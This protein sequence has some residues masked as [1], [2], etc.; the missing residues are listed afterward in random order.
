MTLLKDEQ[1]TREFIEKV[2]VPLEKD[3]VFIMV[4][5]ARKKYCADISSS[6]E[7]VRKDIIRNNDIDNIII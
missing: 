2:L 4:L 5:T 1:S 6:L 3:E 7:V